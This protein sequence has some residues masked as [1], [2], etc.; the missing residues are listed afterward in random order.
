MS[1]LI[2]IV[3]AVCAIVATLTATSTR[4]RQKMAPSA[5]GGGGASAS[6]RA[7]PASAS[8]ASSTAFGGKRIALLKAVLRSATTTTH[9]KV[10]FA[11]GG[12]ETRAGLLSFVRDDDD[13]ETRRAPGER[14]A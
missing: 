9:A 6:A 8:L 10:P 13:D 2:S 14:R 4:R 5:R 12:G 11:R 3:I 1:G 7:S